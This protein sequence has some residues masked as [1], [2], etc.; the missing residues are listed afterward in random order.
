MENYIEMSEA[1]QNLINAGFDLFHMVL[2][3]KKIHNKKFFG[4]IDLKVSE[5]VDGLGR[6][7]SFNKRWL[8]GNEA[9]IDFNVERGIASAWCVDDMFWH[10][11][12]FIMNSPELLRSITKLRTSKFGDRT[13]AFAINEI[14]TL[15]SVLKED[16]TIYEILRGNRPVSWKYTKE[17]AEEEIEEMQEGAIRVQ[18]DGSIKAKRNVR[19][20]Y[21]IKEGKRE[22][23]KPYIKEL[24]RKYR[25]LRYGWTE[26]NEFMH[27]IKPKVIKL[28]EEKYGSGATSEVSEVAKAMKNFTT[29][30]IS[31]LKGLLDG[32]KEPK[33]EPNAPEKVVSKTTLG[34]LKRDELIIMATEKGLTFDEEVTR[35]TLIELILNKK[36]EVEIVE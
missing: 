14:E 34:K 27:E 31:K 9:H 20:K 13:K 21:S 5:T 33:V 26:C 18:G 2:S 3:G 19:Y 12:M 30:D 10:N 16:V 36:E 28:A 4:L 22:E 32:I 8:L 23:Y 29:E 1:K 17:E 15:R 11:R 7:V 6:Q 24:Q 35:A 25:H